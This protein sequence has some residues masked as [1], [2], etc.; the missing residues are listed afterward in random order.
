LTLEP[1]YFEALY[2]E[3]HDPWRLRDRWY[4]QR[5]RMLT[6]AALPRPT[7]RLAFEP[8]CSTGELSALLAPRCQALIASDLVEDAV[9]TARARLATFAHVKVDRRRLPDDW[10]PGRFDL[11]VISELGYY[12]TPVV[13]QRFFRRARASLDETGTIVLCHWRP[14][15]S[16]YPLDG[17][18]VHGE[19]RRFAA[20]ARLHRVAGHSEQDFLLDVWSLD[21]RSVAMAEGLR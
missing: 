13:L 8:G 11:V 21:P 16:D 6:V 4:E 10:P 7:Y 19:F 15:V 17:E 14:A 2:R 20:R 3:C 9:H 18:A 5:K 1:E 12:L